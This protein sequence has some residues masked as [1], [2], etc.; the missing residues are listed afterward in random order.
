[1]RKYLAAM[2]QMNTGRNREENLEYA[3]A[4]VEEAAQI[5]AKLIC[6][7]E[8]M[9]FIGDAAE[10]PEHAEDE[11]G[12]SFRM[13]SGLAKKY[14]VYV[15]GGS[16][17]ER[18]PGERR[19]Y[20]TSYLFSPAGAPLAKYRKMHLFDIAMP[21]GGTARESDH[22]APGGEVVTAHTELGVLGFAICYDLRFPEL[23]RLLA[24][25][26]AQVIL[27][28]ACFTLQTGKDHWEPL[29]R[30]R[31]I[32]NECYVIAPDQIGKNAGMTAFGGSMAVD[33]WGT[34][35]A[36]AGEAPGVTLARI[37]L[38]YLDR[39]RSRMQTLSNR[40]ED[41]YAL[42]TNCGEAGKI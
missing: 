23:F 37:D 10:T 25:R 9:S 2:I 41:V 27:V 16:W 33:P 31:A 21:D 36:R 35:T 39:V 29:L 20:N 14:G 19:V 40:R 24:L 30:A 18:I 7:P 8:T 32:E 13:I 34:V 11:N 4:R 26:G 6:L 3:R 22:V 17:A 1:M 28:P 12:P 38:D 15:H 5:G 42:R